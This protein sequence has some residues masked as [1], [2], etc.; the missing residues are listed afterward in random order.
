MCK[1]AYTFNHSTGKKRQGDDF[2]ATI[3]EIMGPKPGEEGRGK[4]KRGEELGRD[5]GHKKLSLFPR[6]KF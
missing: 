6:L 1:R 2:K 4:G 3:G 5:Y